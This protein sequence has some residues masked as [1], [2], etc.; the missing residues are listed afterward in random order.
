MRDIVSLLEKSPTGVRRLAYR[1]ASGEGL[2]GRVADRMRYRYSPDE[3]PALPPVSDAPTRLLIGPANSAGQGYRWA[4]AAEENLHG[5]AAVSMKGIAADAFDADVDIR[6]PVAVYQRSGS[7]HDALEEFLTCQSHVVWESGL[8]LLGRRYGSSAA[9][10]AQVLTA[11]GV[12]PAFLFH[13]SDI[14]PPA[15]HA[16]QEPWSPFRDGGGGPAHALEATAAANGAM[17]AASGLPVFVSTPD[18]LRWLPEATWCPVVVDAER[19]RSV[20][21]GVPDPSRKLVVVHAPSNAWLKGTE[22]IEPTLARLADE[23]VIEYR[24]ILGVPHAEMPAFYADADVVLDQFVLGIYGVAACEAMAAGK[25]VMSHVDEQTRH[26][27]KVRTGRELPIHETTIESLERDLRRAAA[28]PE[29]FAEIRMAGPIF[30]DEVHSGRRSAT[31][32]AGYLDV[33]A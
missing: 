6:V 10:E 28:A 15:L 21:A 29:D 18:L 3:I 1:V 19:W 7:W 17:A 9:R 24:R 4:R 25:L 33:S 8:P 30:V 32:L 20:A 5:V 23:G 11:R 22:R 13:G 31:A 16:A 14:R 12:R 2:L 27:V 26:E